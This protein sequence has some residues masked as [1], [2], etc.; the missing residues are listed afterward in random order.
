MN[1]FMFGERGDGL[2]EPMEI[3]FLARIGGHG[4]S[5]LW[6]ALDQTS[7]RSL[8]VNMLG[9]TG[10]FHMAN[11]VATAIK[12]QQIQHPSI[13][14]ILAL[15]LTGKRKYVVSPLVTGLNVVQWKEFGP[16]GVFESTRVIAMAARALHHAHVN[17][18]V[19]GCIKPNNLLIGCDLRPYLPDFGLVRRGLLNSKSSLDSAEC[20]RYLAPE[21][22][23]NDRLGDIYGGQISTRLVRF[24]TNC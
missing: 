3:E 17:E 20:D 13:V 12:L 21:Q 8:A 19:H 23:S 15:S 18:I 16:L 10:Q 14:P 6:R 5:S 2:P 11:Y 24:C 4:D 1:A 22:V 7:Q 9:N